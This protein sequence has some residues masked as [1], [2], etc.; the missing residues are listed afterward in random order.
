M[1]P[2]QFL[3]EA[4]MIDLNTLRDELEHR[5]RLAVCEIHGLAE[6]A[7]AE[8]SARYWSRARRVSVAHAGARA[9]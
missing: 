4:N 3:D 7:F 6:R 9:F 5:H 1:C 2:C 8:L